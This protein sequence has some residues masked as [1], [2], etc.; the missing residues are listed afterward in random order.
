MVSAG[1][2]NKIGRSFFGDLAL[3]EQALARGGDEIWKTDAAGQSPGQAP[4][5]G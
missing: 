5:G 4:A 3:I 2:L 1:L